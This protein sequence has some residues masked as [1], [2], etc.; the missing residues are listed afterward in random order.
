MRFF[1][2]TGLHLGRSTR[3]ENSDHEKVYQSIDLL[4]RITLGEEIFVPEKNCCNRRRKC[5]HGYYQISA[6][7]LQRKK[8]GRVDITAT[9]LEPADGML[10]DDEEVIEAG[11]E[12]AVITPAYGPQKIELDE[13]GE[14][15]GLE[16]A[17]CLQIFDEDGKFNPKFDLE[18]RKFYPADM[19]VESI[20]QASDL[21][22]IPEKINEGIE[23]TPRRQIDVDPDFQVKNNPWLFAGGDIV[24]GPD[25]ISGI[26]NGR[27]AAVGIDRYLRGK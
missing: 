9:C 3:I 24:K 15:K 20:G 19:I 27:L 26:A 8:Y 13:N 6:A 23:Y 4:R 10:A 16:V 1:A 2:G 12:G 7:R 11:E 5:C 21:S 25:V 17:R 22:Y 14:M 18:D